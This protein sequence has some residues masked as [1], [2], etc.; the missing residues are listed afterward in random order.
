MAKFLDTEGIN[1]RLKKIIKE[2]TALF[3]KSNKQSMEDRY[4]SE[5]KQWQKDFDKALKELK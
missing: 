1:Y 2:T 3:K 4:N 5:S